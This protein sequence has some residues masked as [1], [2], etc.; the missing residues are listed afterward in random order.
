MVHGSVSGAPLFPAASPVVSSSASSCHAMLAPSQPPFGAQS[1]NTAMSIIGAEDEDFEN[2]LDPTVDDQCSHFNSI[3]L[4]KGRPTH[5]LVFLQHVMLQF[6]CARVLCYLH[7]DLFKQF[8]SKETKKQFVDF[9]N[10]F[11]DKG[12]ILRVPVPT[13]VTYELDRTRPDLLSEDVQKRFAQDIQ[14]QLAPD[15]LRQLE[16]FK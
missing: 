3:E 10:T 2:D 5:L 8:S 6:D 11:L 7:A 4:L 9:Y 16:D 14:A 13:H 12:A 1:S 15:V